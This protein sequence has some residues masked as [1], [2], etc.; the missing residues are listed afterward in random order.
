MKCGLDFSK[1]RVRVAIKCVQCLEY[2]T[3]T[4]FD[5][6]CLLV[7]SFSVAAPLSPSVKNISN[8]SP[9]KQTLNMLLVLLG[10]LHVEKG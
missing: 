6:C 3:V 7:M 1:L 2:F 8:T 4:A 10:L 5:P 9:P